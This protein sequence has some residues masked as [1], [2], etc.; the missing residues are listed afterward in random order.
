MV[1]LPR[2]KSAQAAIIGN[3]A[4]GVLFPP[5]TLPG[6]SAYLTSK[7]AVA[8]ILEF[9]A[10]ENPDVFIASVHPGAVD[11]TMFRKSEADPREWPADT[12]ETFQLRH[13]P[14]SYTTFIPC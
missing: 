6:F 5:A 10:V 13:C 8:K 11:T 2:V 7:L 9:L 3:N 4:G 1:F 12:R 14:S